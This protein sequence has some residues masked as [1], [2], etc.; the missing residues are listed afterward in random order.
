MFVYVMI[1]LLAIP[2]T[3]FVTAQIIVHR[4]AFNPDRTSTISEKNLPP[5][6]K[7]IILET[8]DGERLPSLY[9]HTEGATKVVLYF[10]GKAGNISKRLPTIHEFHKMGVHCLCMG[11][12]GY[13]LSSGS[14]SEQGI[15][16]DG[17]AALSYLL[18][19]GF[20][21]SDIYLYGR[22]LGSTVAC[23]LGQ[24]D[25]YGG[26]ILASPLSSGV[27]FI[28]DPKMRWM[29][30]FLGKPFLSKEKVKK[31]TTPTLILHGTKD[32]YIPFFMGEILFE[33]TASQKEFV[34]ISGGG[35]DNLSTDFGTHFWPRIEAF[36]KGV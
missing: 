20:K 30:P 2:L 35:H 27:D 19:K 31:F 26:I 23:E 4:I 21:K 8:S 18:R 13:G 14:P 28:R 12:R 10:H 5:N 29:I 7:K 1:T 32:D 25:T 34:A 33:N 24:R 22:S 15:Y 11:Y 6:V 9:S 16:R 3:L 36:I 17:E